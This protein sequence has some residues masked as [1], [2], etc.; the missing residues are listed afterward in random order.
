MLVIKWLKNAGVDYKHDKECCSLVG[1]KRKEESKDVESEKERA[2]G[3]IQENKERC[4]KQVRR[5]KAHKRENEWVRVCRQRRPK[6]RLR[7]GETNG[8]DNKKKWG[9]GA[10]SISGKRGRILGRHIEK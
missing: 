4:A 6:Q 8:K 10:E 2:G 3:K 1:T 7:R 9:G 5:D